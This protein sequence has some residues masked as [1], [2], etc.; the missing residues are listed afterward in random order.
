MLHSWH[1][2]KLD[3]PFSTS[4][5]DQYKRELRNGLLNSS[6]K[7]GEGV[8]KSGEP[9]SWLLDCREVLLTGHYLHYAGRLLWERLRPY[10]P[11]MVGGMTMAADPL[12]IAC[13][14][15]PWAD[16]YPLKAFTIRKEP[17]AYGLRKC[18]KGPPIQHGTRI[19]LLDDLVSS[20]K[21]L[22]KALE[23]LEPFHPKVVA[24]GVLINFQ[25]VG[26]KWLQEQKLPL[27]FL[28]TL[29]DLGIAMRSPSGGATGK[30]RWIW[31]LLNT[32]KYSIPKSSPC[33]EQNKIFVGS[34][35]GFLLSL[36]LDGK[37]CW[38]YPVRD[39]V[40]GIHSSP[41]VHEGKVYFGAYD[42]F[43]YCLDAVNGALMWEV[44]RGQWISSSP[45]VDPKSNL[46]FIGIGYGK[47]GGSL[48]APEAK[49][50]KL[51]WELKATH[52]MLSSPSVQFCSLSGDRGSE[53]QHHLCCRCINRYRALAISHR[54][55][56]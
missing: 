34:D 10:Q 30:L 39:I 56:S 36:T 53:R 43:V 49:T 48:V 24:V 20:G 42:G 11:E 38:R 15:R 7:L 1:A 40:Q 35:N 31:E 45:A 33:I 8:G 51:V 32:G 47:A 12:T 16:N 3:E 4:L 13:S 44:Q 54:W 21:T 14:M 18:V 41:L 17:K 27:E 19:V 25:R 46:I 6:L 52:H 37:E 2:S 22:Q 5:A 28:F 50:G 9:S 23:A 29:S 55:G 26:A